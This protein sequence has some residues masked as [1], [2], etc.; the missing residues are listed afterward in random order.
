LKDPAAHAAKPLFS[1]AGQLGVIDPAGRHFPSRSIMKSCPIFPLVG[2]ITAVGPNILAKGGALC[3]YLEISEQGGRVRRLTIV[4]AV[5]ALAALV[6]QHAI[7]LF[8]F[9]V[10]QRGRHHAR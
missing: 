10:R 5:E 8:L 3:R 9:Y 2:T 4:R 7:G 6:E 1:C